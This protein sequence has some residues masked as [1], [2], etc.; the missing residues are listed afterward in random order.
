MEA[1]ECLNIKVDK[2]K[3]LRLCAIVS[4]LTKACHS[5]QMAILPSHSLCYQAYN[6]VSIK[7]SICKAKRKLECSLSFTYKTIQFVL[8][9]RFENC[10]QKKYLYIG[11]EQCN[12]SWLCENLTLS[13]FKCI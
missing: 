8:E 2:G 7:S 3:Y 1:F 6:S 11:N 5:V 9:Y 13:F 10:F 4:S 12:T